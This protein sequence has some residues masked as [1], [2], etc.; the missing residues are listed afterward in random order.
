ML[1]SAAIT[2]RAIARR[3]VWTR[4]L[5]FH[6]NMEPHLPPLNAPL[7]AVEALS[8][9]TINAVSFTIMLT[10]GALWAFDVSSIAEL[11]RRTRD[12][13]GYEKAI[14]AERKEAGGVTQEEWMYQVLVD[15]DEK[16]NSALPKK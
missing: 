4:P 6:T 2:R 9:A 15:E 7:E 13:L 3:N 5:F 16:K 1:F 10:G 11:R 12:K 14:E 8:V